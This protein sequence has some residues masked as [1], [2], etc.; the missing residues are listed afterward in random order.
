MIACPC[1]R[2]SALANSLGKINIM[3]A[4]AERDHASM[5]KSK[6][7]MKCGM[8]WQKKMRKNAI[9]VIRAEKTSSKQRVRRRRPKKKSM[10]MSLHKRSYLS[11]DLLSKTYF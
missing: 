8:C 4:S 7:E 6:H 9:G 3:A 2:S 5:R 10:C 1:R 11:S